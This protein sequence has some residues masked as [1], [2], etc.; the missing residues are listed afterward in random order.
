MLNLTNNMNKARS[1]YRVFCATSYTLITIYVWAITGNSTIPENNNWATLCF[2]YRKP[3]VCATCLDKKRF[4]GP[5]LCHFSCAMRKWS[6]SWS[7]LAFRWHCCHSHCI[8]VVI[9]HIFWKAYTST[10]HMLSEFGSEVV[11]TGNK[12]INLE[13]HVVITVSQH[14]LTSNLSRFLYQINERPYFSHRHI[15]MTEIW[16]FMRCNYGEIN[17]KTS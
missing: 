12:G 5:T 17:D 7:L 15:D 3:W 8:D 1:I 14:W 4:C 16:R 10:T 9:R 13:G 2:V 6:W 11:E